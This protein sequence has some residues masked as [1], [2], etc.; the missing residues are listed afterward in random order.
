MCHCNAWQLLQRL[1]A[2]WSAED[3]GLCALSHKW[4]IYIMPPI[5]HLSPPPPTP[6]SKAEGTLKKNVKAGGSGGAMG[7]CLDVVFSA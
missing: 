2:D 5:P 7:H 3:K 1:K 6:A 4:D